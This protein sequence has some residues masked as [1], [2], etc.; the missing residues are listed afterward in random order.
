MAA[1]SAIIVILAC[2][3]LSEK[4]K[5]ISGLLGH[6]HAPKLEVVNMCSQKSRDVVAAEP[7]ELCL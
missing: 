7:R 4:E 3:L 1:V 5:L 6:T 2:A